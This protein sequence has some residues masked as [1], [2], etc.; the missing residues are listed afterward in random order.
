MKEFLSRNG[1]EFESIDVREL[2]DPMSTL[3]AVTGGPVGT[4]T[5]VVD[6]EVRLGFD[7]EWLR[8]ELGL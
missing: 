5:V 3:R 2:D 1:V 8:R 4:P 6:G 7:E